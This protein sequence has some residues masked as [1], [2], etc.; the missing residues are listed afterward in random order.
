[1]GPQMP[2][3]QS[4]YERQGAIAWWFVMARIG[5]GLREQ[6]EVPKELPPKMLWLVR[7]LDEPRLI[8]REQLGCRS[9]ADLLLEVD[10]RELLAAV[11]FHDK[12]RF[13]FLDGPGRREAAG[14]GYC[15]VRGELAPE[16]DLGAYRDLTVNSET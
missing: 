16:S 6:Y 15:R 13:Q 1:M 7:K 8:L 10:I 11:V 9:P 4:F 14:D 2:E 3:T 5:Q 12:A